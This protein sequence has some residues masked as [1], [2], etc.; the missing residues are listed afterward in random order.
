MAT[1]V[2][3]D[4]HNLTL[5]YKTPRDGYAAAR[6]LIDC[7]GGFCTVR[8]G[9]VT[10]LLKL[11]V[12]GLMSLLPCRELVPAI[13]AQEQA[14]DEIFVRPGSMM[15]LSL[16]SL[17]CTQNAVITDKGLFDGRTQQFYQQFIKE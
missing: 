13:A 9:E 1:T 10:G 3:H 12:A 2:S 7:G 5:C 14:T 16:V 17:A 11:P 8:R 15:K 6:A 4:C